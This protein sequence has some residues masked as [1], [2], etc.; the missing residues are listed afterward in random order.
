MKISALCLLTT[1]PW[2]SQISLKLICQAQFICT[3]EVIPVYL[4]HR[5]H[6]CCGQP[7]K[8]PATWRSRKTSPS[9]Q[10]GP[11]SWGE[12]LFSTLVVCPGSLSETQD[13]LTSY[14]PLLGEGPLAQCAILKFP[15]Q[16]THWFLSPS[17]TLTD[18]RGWRPP[19][20]WKTRLLNAYITPQI[21]TEPE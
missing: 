12:G 1:S 14:C 9:P 2:T 18:V 20:L 10:Y 21:Y 16:I 13:S 19:L 8:L 6:S 5:G 11:Q 7:G 4:A 17:W 3:W 15:I